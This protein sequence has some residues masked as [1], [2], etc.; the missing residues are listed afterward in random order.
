M[1]E[2]SHFEGGQVSV[3][4][5][6]R[7]R[8]TDMGRKKRTAGATWTDL[9]RERAHVLASLRDVNERIE[10]LRPRFKEPPPLDGYT[11]KL[12]GTADCPG[13]AG[14]WLED[15]LRSAV[16]WRIISKEE[17]TA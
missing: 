12:G 17:L 13:F 8:K 14:L 15:Y 2:I 1:A 7:R 3:G 16:A 11:D 4:P 6:S 5:I 9:Q 10:L